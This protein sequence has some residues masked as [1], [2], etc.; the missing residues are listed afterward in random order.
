MFL[1]AV[2]VRRARTDTLDRLLPPKERAQAHGHVLLEVMA[3]S[4]VVAIVKPDVAVD[5]HQKVT[6]LIWCHHELI[7]CKPRIA[8]L[9]QA[10]VDLM[11]DVEATMVGQ[12]V[13]A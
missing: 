10:A 11:G 3:R 2:R 1:T 6:G 13:A 5:G 8:K 12:Q 7:G 4:E 9:V